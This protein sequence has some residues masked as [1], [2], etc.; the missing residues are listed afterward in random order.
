ME[1]Q[2]EELDREEETKQKFIKIFS[3]YNLEE[4]YRVREVLE[5]EINKVKP[6]QDQV[7]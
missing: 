6:S 7:Y 4:L 3:E 5:E 1:N 2:Q